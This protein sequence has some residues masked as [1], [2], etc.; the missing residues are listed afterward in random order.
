MGFTT[1]VEAA[2]PAACTQRSATTLEEALTA[3]QA[4][5]REQRRLR[6]GPAV[7]VASEQR[8]RL[9]EVAFRRPV[10]GLTEAELRVLAQRVERLLEPAAPLASEAATPPASPGRSWW[11]W[12]GKRKQ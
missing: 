6:A 3:L 12:W 4:S 8:Q 2:A 9:P 11:R 7:D 10:G 1:A 5:L